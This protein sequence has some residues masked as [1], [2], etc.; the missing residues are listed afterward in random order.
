MTRLVFASCMHA[1]ADSK[2]AVWKDAA[3]HQ[4]D[5]LILGGDNIYMD[6]G[7]DLYQSQHWPLQKFADEMSKRYA[8][9]FSVKSFQTL[10][11][12][13]P[14][15]QVIGVWDDHDFGWNDCYGTDT[16]DG[17]PEKQR[18]AASL[19]HHYFD[20]LNLRPL[21]TTLPPLAVPDLLSPPNG[22]RDIYRAVT[23]GNV[24]LLLCD[25]RRYRER[26]QPGGGSA[27]ILGAA[28]EQW[29]FNELGSGASAYVIVSGSTMTGAK[30][31]SW[32]Y[33]R[34]FFQ[35]KF[36]PKV[37]GKNVIFLGGDIHKNRLPPRKPNWPVE[38]VS[39]AAALG[40]FFFNS[41]YGV[42]ELDPAEAR[43][44]LYRDSKVEFTGK[45]NWGT[46]T[47]KTNMVAVMRPTPPKLSAAAA[48]AQRNRAM[49]SLRSVR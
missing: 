17:M 39:S 46:G 16:S 15:N 1:G 30:D 6:F 18:I 4:P 11:K 36:L 35:N 25:V 37:S 7:I 28:Q 41:R 27:S 29:L 24:K 44:F 3:A 8:A 2:Q 48:T 22:M 31:Q 40:T 32:D 34:D 12:K 23:V 13:I 45:L 43:F 26:A 14:A 47:F 38:A 9:Q 19:Y 49:Q 10:V 21:P 5:W 33:Y 20:S 42:V